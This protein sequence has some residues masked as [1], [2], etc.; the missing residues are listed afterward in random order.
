ML[1]IALAQNVADV[2][3]DRLGVVGIEP[4]VAVLRTVVGVV[5]RIMVVLMSLESAGLPLT[6]QLDAGRVDERDEANARRQ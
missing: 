3:A 6:E 5:R 4:D 2:A 1:G